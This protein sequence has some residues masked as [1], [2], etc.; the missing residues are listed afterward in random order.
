MAAEKE[1]GVGNEEIHLV[2]L[3]DY[4]S[5]GINA[6]PHVGVATNDIDSGKSTGISILKHGAPP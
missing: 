6:V 4:C 3:L 5:K 1:Q 2:F